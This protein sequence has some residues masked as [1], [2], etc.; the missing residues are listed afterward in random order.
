MGKQKVVEYGLGKREIGPEIAL[1][2][3]PPW[4]FPKPSVDVDM[5]EGRGEWGE[6]VRRCVERYIDN[7]F[8]LFLRTYTDGSKA[9]VSGRLG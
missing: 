6:D 5:I 8:Y 2:K 9:T 7:Q 1:G 3:V 4:L